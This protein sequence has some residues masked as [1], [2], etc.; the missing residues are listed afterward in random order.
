MLVLSRK[1]NESIVI[2]ENVTL[3]VVEIRGDKVRLGIQ[4]PEHVSVHR[5][6]VWARIQEGS[7][8]RKAEEL[9][10][11]SAARKACSGEPAEPPAVPP[12]ET[13]A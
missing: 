9:A 11:R 3:V 13:A 7:P 12:G 6:E 4:A 5:S 1:R 2:N 8:D 10:Q